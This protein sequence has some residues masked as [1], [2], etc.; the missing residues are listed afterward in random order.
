M[1]SDSLTKTAVRDS[2][3]M[4]ATEM[5]RAPV[6]D[7]VR[8]AIREEGL[9]TSHGQE[10]HSHRH[11]QRSHGHEQQGQQRHQ[12]QKGKQSK[13]SKQSEQSQDSGG[14]SKLLWGTIMLGVMGLAYA[15]RRR[16]RSNQQSWS[17]PSPESVASDQAETGYSSE[18]EMQT[19][20]GAGESDD[21]S[22]STSATGEQ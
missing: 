3:R 17:G 22:H 15:A 4:V 13:Q 7:A 10:Q 12:S 1:S 14:R 16:M 20:E 21:V 2:A 19:S 8:D 18:G 11:E 6:K 9:T 5:I